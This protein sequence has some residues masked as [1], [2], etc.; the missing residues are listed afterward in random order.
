MVEENISFSEK[1][2]K[3]VNALFNLTPVLS[4]FAHPIVDRYSKL[5][6]SII[7]PLKT[8]LS[9]QFMLSN[10]YFTDI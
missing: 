6:Y 3:M 8:L 2:L 5:K 10:G 9:T 7:Q 1:I 4:I